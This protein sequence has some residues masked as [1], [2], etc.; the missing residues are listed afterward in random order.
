M[1]GGMRLEVGAFPE[2]VELSD[3]FMGAWKHLSSN[4]EEKSTSCYS[5]LH[6]SHRLTTT[7]CA[8][9]ATDD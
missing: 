8:D 3:W 7:I 6:M 5:D 9:Q 2:V 4:L 1:W